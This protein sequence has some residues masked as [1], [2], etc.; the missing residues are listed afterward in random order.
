VT[1]AGALRDG[2][3]P[4]CCVGRALALSSPAVAV[5][6]ASDALIRGMLVLVATRAPST[7][8]WGA[9][10]GTAMATA[11]TSISAKALVVNTRRTRLLL[12]VNFLLPA[13]HTR[14]TAGT[15]CASCSPTAHMVAGRTRLDLYP[16]TSNPPLQFPSQFER[17]LPAGRSFCHPR[18][19]RQSSSGPSRHYDYSAFVYRRNGPSMPVR[20]QSDDACTAVDMPAHGRCYTLTLLAGAGC[21][22]PGSQ[23]HEVVGAPEPAPLKSAPVRYRRNPDLLQCRGASGMLRAYLATMTGE[24]DDQPARIADRWI[25]GGDL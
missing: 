14:C 16:Q 10:A 21:G 12:M 11:R 15:C 20:W 22:S 25:W 2:L 8:T 24:I 4:S 23:P 5:A 1:N 7:R 17:H 3:P 13:S 18:S 19:A 9:M 6:V